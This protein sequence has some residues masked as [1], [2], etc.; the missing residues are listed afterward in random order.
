[1]LA[2]RTFTAHSILT[3]IALF[4]GIL[5]NQPFFSLALALLWALAFVTWLEWHNTWR[6]L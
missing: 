4:W 1:M 5:V 2:D 3:V 6:N